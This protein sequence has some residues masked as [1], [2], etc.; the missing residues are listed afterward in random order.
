MKKLI[1]SSVILVMCGK[2]S[3]QSKDLKTL[4]NYMTGKYSSTRQHKA[5]TANFY[6]IRLQI[7][8]I[9]KE[10]KDGVW[11]YVEQAVAGSESKPYRQRV[12][13]VTERTD[14]TFESA[15]FT[16]ADPLRFAGNAKTFE[17]ILAPD[18]LK[19]REGCSVFL[20]KINDH[21]FGGGTEAQKCASERRG[22]AY[23]TAEVIITKEQLRSWDRGFNEKGEQVWG[24]TKGGYLF[25]KE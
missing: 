17:K 23:A 22:A 5:D 3:S 8:P 16:F 6:D 12:Y 2:M 20:R 7:V 24:A 11:L 4:A 25:E 10:L 15:V 18:S 9:W 19:L 21:T 1:L 13:H 14:H